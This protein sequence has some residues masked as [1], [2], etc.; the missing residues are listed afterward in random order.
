MQ[1]RLTLVVTFFSILFVVGCAS[2]KPK[3]YKER[4]YGEKPD[5]IRKPLVNHMIDKGYPEPT[6]TKIRVDK[7]LQKIY[8]YNSI[9]PRPGAATTFYGWGAKLMVNIKM[10]SGGYSGWE[11]RFILIRDGEVIKFKRTKE[12]LGDTSGYRHVW[13]DSD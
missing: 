11:D 13:V 12:M 5:E 10:T 2:M 8:I 3:Y 6:A 1:N 7:P 4:D 9:D